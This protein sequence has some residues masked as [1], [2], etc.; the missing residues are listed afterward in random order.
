MP[1]RDRKEANEKV[2]KPLTN[3]GRRVVAAKAPRLVESG[4]KAVLLT[5]G[6]S[7]QVMKDVLTDL[8]I[9]R[10][11]ESVRLSK[12]NDGIHPFETGGETT[13][14]FLGVKA[15]SGLYAMA[16]ST[17]KR[18]DNLTMGRF[19]DGH[20]YDVVEFGVEDFRNMRSFGSAASKAV[21]G[22]RPCMVFLGEAF[23]ESPGMKLARDVLIDFFRGR[24]LQMV[25][26]KWL[27]RVMVFTATGEGTILMRQ[28]VVR[29]KKSGSSVPRVA[30]TEMGPS[31]SLV[32]RR[33]RNAPPDV[34]REAL[35]SAPQAKAAKNTRTEPLVGKLARVYMPRQELDDIA[36][37]KI[38]GT[39]RKKE[40]AGEEG[41]AGG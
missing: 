5:N 8:H 38:K 1:A 32:L 19:Y 22:T 28:C 3:K 2:V 39:K 12:K 26:L 41:G 23:E 21:A 37:R 33:H 27:D 36:L 30:L 15:D 24:V 40:A 10:K 29:F 16:S 34:A 13:L 9:L 35:R 14:E 4:K 7:S 31:A 25:N 17:K 6:K 11:G 18:P 20:L